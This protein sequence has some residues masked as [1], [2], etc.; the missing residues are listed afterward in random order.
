MTSEAVIPEGYLRVDIVLDVRYYNGN[1]YEHDDEAADAARVTNVETALVKFKDLEYSQAVW[2]SPPNK[3]DSERWADFVTAYEAWIK[4]HYVHLPT[5]SE[6]VKRVET[7]GSK[8]FEA[9]IKQKTQMDILT[10]GRLMPFQLEGTIQVIGLLATLVQQHECWPFLLIVPNSTCQNWRREIRRWA[11]SLRAVTYYGDAKGLELAF[12][13]ELFP[14]GKKDLACHIVVVSNQVPARLSGQFLRRIPW[15]GMIVDEAQSLKNEESNLYGALSGIEAPFKILLTGTPLQNNVRELFNL[16]QFL[17]DTVEAKALEKE[18]KELTAEKVQKLHELFRPFILRRVKA[19]VLP[20]LPPMAQIIVPV[21]MTAVQKQLYKAVLGNNTEFIMKVFKKKNQKPEADFKLN[22]A[23]MH[24]R[25]I[26]CHPYI[27][28]DGIKEPGTDQSLTHRHF[29]EASAKFQLLEIMLPRLRERGHR[30]LIFSQ[31]LAMLDCMEDLLHGV[32]LPFRRLDGS[33]DSLVRQKNIDAF[34]APDSPLFAFL[35]ST[36]AGGVGI[37]LATADT[38]IILDPDFNPHQDMQALSRA[39]R[40]GQKKKVLIFQLM[41]RDSVEERIMQIGRKK[42]ALDHVLI[43]SLDEQDEAKTDVRSILEYG[44]AALF[45]SDDPERNIHYDIASV[46]KLL[47]RSQAETT[48]IDAR[49]SQFSFARLWA[50]DKDELEDSLNANEESS[51]NPTVWDQLLEEREKTAAE[52]PGVADGPG[53]EPKL[54]RGMRKREIVNYASQVDE[55]DGRPAPKKGGKRARHS[56]TVDTDFQDDEYAGEDDSE[57]EAVSQAAASAT[58]MPVRKRARSENVPVNPATSVLGNRAVFT[59]QPFGP[60]VAAP[61]AGNPRLPCAGPCKQPKHQDRS[62]YGE[63]ANE[64]A[65]DSWKNVFVGGL[66]TPPELVA[67]GGVIQFAIAAARDL[68]TGEDGFRALPAPGTAERYAV[69]TSGRACELCRC[70]HFGLGGVCPRLVD[71]GQLERI[72]LALRRA[73]DGRVGA[74]WTLFQHPLEYVRRLLEAA[75][76]PGPATTGTPDLAYVPEPGTIARAIAS[77]AFCPPPPYSLAIQ[78]IQT[79]QPSPYQA[80]GPAAVPM[81]PIPAGRMVSGPIPV[82]ASAWDFMNQM[83]PAPPPVPSSLPPTGEV[84]PPQPDDD[85]R[86]D[87]DMSGPW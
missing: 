53:T 42:M 18:Y 41:M 55:G 32:G 67:H 9:E 20:F 57:E 21:T 17:D 36:R 77:G 86:R 12:K 68:F 66:S 82:A 16:L 6:L 52:A 47:D 61:P 65:Q 58:Q 76:G 30:V 23:L 22:N 81:A 63:I 64:V 59:P 74:A 11:P 3:E 48:P 71:P 38:V 60:S 34:N 33:M 87:D 37:N 27:C 10:G 7:A 44:T 5:R 69:P 40:Y 13:H 28:E 31:F 72:I 15:A 56:Q 43:Q 14:R 79:Q 54:G 85:A 73:Q 1:V 80:S 83:N 19:D 70:F 2:E 84:P 35:L 4:G 29:V 39:Y 24:L 51:V 78:Q 50:E 75:T 45:D 62:L 46:E 8:N 25:K 49:R 26:L